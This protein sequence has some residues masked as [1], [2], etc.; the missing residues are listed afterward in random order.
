MTETSSRIF[1]LENPPAILVSREIKLAPAGATSA[2]AVPTKLA[3]SGAVP[4]SN[5]PTTLLKIAA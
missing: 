1:I 5:V 3:R 2:V 4:A